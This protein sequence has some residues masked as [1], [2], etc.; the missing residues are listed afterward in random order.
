MMDE[1]TCDLCNGWDEDLQNGICECCMEVQ[2][3]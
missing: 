3:G 2:N 1:F